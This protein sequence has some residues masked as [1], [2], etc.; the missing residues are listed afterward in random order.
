MYGRIYTLVYAKDSDSAFEIAREVAPKI[1]GFDRF[2]VAAYEYEFGKEMHSMCRKFPPA[3]QVSTVRFPTDDKRGME[4]VNYAM[5]CNRASFKRNMV[6]IRY[7][8][9]NYT[10]DQ[11]FDGVK[12]KG[13]VFIEIE[14]VS[15][16]NQPVVF[17]EDLRYACGYFQGSDCWLYDFRGKPITSFTYI[18][19]LL[20]DSDSNPFYID[21]SG[22][23]DPDWGPH[24]WCQPLWIV[25]FDVEKETMWFS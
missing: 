23:Q 15:I 17:R 24:I 11:L 2:F 19:Q 13:K 16:Q 8:I 22:G 10:D 18:K 3:L 25:P 4:V 20:N 9:A 1:N 21:H 14:G 7:M 5:E 12:P 6:G